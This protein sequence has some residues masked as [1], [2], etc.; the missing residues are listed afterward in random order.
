MKTIQGDLIKLAKEGYFSVIVHGCNC[1][2]TM[3]KGIAVQIKKEFPLAYAIDQSTPK[4]D[5]SKLGTISAAYI[6]EYIL[7]VV[8][9]YTQ[10]D[11]RPTYTDDGT[12]RADYDAIRSVFKQVK[13]HYPNHTIGYPK[14][15]A[16]L[17]GGDW[18]IISAI[19]DEELAGCDH[20]CVEYQ[21]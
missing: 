16:G 13:L 9:G 21:P 18:D 8:N 5:R 2:C 15:G 7:V 20:T 1:F 4:G 14:I 6:Q 11:F 17:A 3:G 10:Y 12:C 19:I